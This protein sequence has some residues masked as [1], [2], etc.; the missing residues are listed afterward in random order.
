MGTQ[1]AKH[2][3]L[4]LVSADG[5]KIYLKS[6][7]RERVAGVIDVLLK[8]WKANAN[9][10]EDLGYFNRRI[11]MQAIIELFKNTPATADLM[12]KPLPADC[13]VD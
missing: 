4:P 9:P 13:I 6:I 12:A 10:G 5:E 8:Y 11:G 3:G 2:Q 1:D 7:P